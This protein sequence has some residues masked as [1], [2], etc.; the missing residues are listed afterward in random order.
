M[1]PSKWRLASMCV[2]LGCA[3]TAA[4]V[5]AAGF[6]LRE[7]NTSS[8]HGAHSG[9][10]VKKGDATTIFNNPATMASLDKHAVAFSGNVIIPSFKL[11]D[12]RATNPLAP[13]TAVVGTNG[14]DAGSE[15]FIPAAYA[16]Y[17]LNSNWNLGFS[18]TVPWGL[19]T[20]YDKNWVGRYYGI[21]SELQTLNF[22]PMVSW[23]PSHRWFGGQWSF[24][25]GVQ[26]QH[27]S[28]KLSNAVATGGNDAIIDLDAHDWG[29]GLLLGATYDPL[30][31]LHFG[32]SYRGYVKHTLDG[33]ATVTNRAGPLVSVIPTHGAGIKASMTTPEVVTLSVAYDVNDWLTFMSDIQWTRWNCLNELRVKYNDGTRDSVESLEWSNTLFYSLGAELT[34]Y[35]DWAFRAGIAYDESPT[36][37]STRGPRI[38]DADRFWVSLGVDYVGF[39]DTGYGDLTFGLG[40]THI[41]F[42]KKSI[43]ISQ[44]V[45]G[46]GTSFLRGGVDAHADLIGLQFN[47]HF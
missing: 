33:K 20:E 31:C 25:G 12:A 2:G 11:D 41:F 3:V 15:A 7:F 23:K 28:A 14:G 1:R 36:K 4:N 10:A 27:A 21:R 13:T 17:N 47:W 26:I 43:N 29:V 6:Q 40:Y 24:G 19:K 45:T 18:F 35:K 42:R 46:V 9:T 16:V 37:D 22:A 38:P 5:Q 8:L 30:D 32:L 34:P 39:K 44:T